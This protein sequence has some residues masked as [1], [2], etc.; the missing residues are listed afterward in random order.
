VTSTGRIAWWSSGVLAALGLTALILW[1]LL[2]RSVATTGFAAIDLR[3]LDESA[4]YHRGRLKSFDS[5]AREVVAQVAGP[6]GVSRVLDEAADSTRLPADFAYLDMMIRPELYDDADIIYVK[7]KP[8]RAQLAAALER[9][10]AADTDTL[11][12]FISTGLISESLLRSPASLEMLQ[13]WSRDVVRT[14][15]H[16]NAIRAAMHFRS[17]ETLATSLRII[18]PPDG[19]RDTPWLSPADLWSDGSGGLTEGQRLAASMDPEMRD[20]LQRSWA[21]FIEAWRAEDT[22]RAAAMLATFCT[23]IHDAAPELYPERSRLLT[24][25]TYFR[26]GSFTW[27]WIIYLF[28]V[29][30]LLMAVA[31]KWEGARMLGLGMFSVAFLLHTGTIA[32][33]WYVSGRWPNSN[34]FEAVTTSVWFGALVAVALELV[35]RRTALRNLFAIGA[36]VA[37]MAA[38]M[39]VQFIPKLDPAINNMMPILHDLWLYIHT[40]TIIASYALIAMAAVTSILYLLRR[41]F[42]APADFAR[43]GGTGM[44]LQDGKRTVTLGEVLDGATLIMMELSFVMLWAGIIMGAVW[45]DHSWGRPWGWDPKEVFALNTFLV[46]LILIHVRMRV[47]DKGLWTAVLAVA[48]C[49][50]M[51]FNWIVINFVIAGLHSYA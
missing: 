8:M 29:L 9:A 46:F 36:S 47:A 48:G 22:D 43:V 42:G 41:L 7:K 33:R 21:A 34:M 4:V 11:D 37:C 44:L 40:N 25:S 45:A 5:Y 13:I 39:S 14:A 30:F 24:E 3:P 50:V 26:A 27:S 6:K 16:V 32:V 35:A 15:S 19:N 10:D 23:A 38:M 17:P 2:G 51:L 1:M 20:A 31:F 18:P 12:E 28:A 49:G